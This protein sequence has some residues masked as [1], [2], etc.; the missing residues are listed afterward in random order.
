MFLHFTVDE[1][2]G[3]FSDSLKSDAEN[4]VKPP[5]VRVPPSGTKKGVH[6]AKATPV[7]S[8]DKMCA[9]QSVIVP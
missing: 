2:T 9:T 3:A 5:R 4:V 6:Q 8:F 1:E 7:V